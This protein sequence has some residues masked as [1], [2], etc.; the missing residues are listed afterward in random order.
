MDYE[1]KS[2]LTQYDRLKPVDQRVV[3]AYVYREIMERISG[4]MRRPGN[5]SF[6][7][8]YR[9]V[10]AG[11]QGVVPEQKAGRGAASYNVEMHIE[12]MRDVIATNPMFLGSIRAALR[13]I[14]ASYP[15]VDFCAAVQAYI[16]FNG[17]EFDLSR[18]THSLAKPRS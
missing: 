5:P 4:Q 8:D 2:P 15:G 10:H 6:A 17:D 1:K 12:V 18:D 11:V 14:E 9:L 3:D 7:A 13:E 16:D